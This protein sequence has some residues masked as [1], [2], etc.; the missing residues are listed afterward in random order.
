VAGP[1]HMRL[2]RAQRAMLLAVALPLTLAA[3]P[4]AG[5]RAE[6]PT[7]ALKPVPATANGYFV[8]SGR[9]GQVLRGKVEV[10]N[11]GSQPGETHLYAVDATTGQTSGA[12]YRSRTEPKRAVGRWT[13]LGAAALRLGPGQSRVVPFAVRVPAE[14]EPG[15]YLGGIVAQRFTKAVTGKGG[16]GGETGFQVKVQALS[17]LAIQV[18]VP[19]P[20][21]AAMTLSGI[22]PGDQPGHQSLLLGIGNVGNVMLKGDGSVK[23]VSRSGRQVQDQEFAL[24]TFLPDTRIEYPVYI[25][26]KALGP[27]R[28]RG[29][30]SLSYSGHHLT[31][32]FPFRISASDTEQVF[33]S[34]ASDITPL[35]SSSSSSSD[36]ALVYALIAVCLLSLATAFYFWRRRRPA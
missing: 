20:Q 33:G 28:Y 11:V 18:N 12:V 13:S 23:V 27:G 35:A 34:T 8:F 16:N 3:L 32:S 7:F 10:A 29:T 31:R 4:T 14:L 30:V 1:L 19:G 2:R 9:P 25:K 5:A 6:G 17:V 21:H 22:T 24:D 15:Q 36:G 26:G